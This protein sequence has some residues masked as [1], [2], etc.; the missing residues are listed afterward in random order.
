[1]GKEKI[2]GGEVKSGG[3]AARRSIAVLQGRSAHDCQRVTGIRSAVVQT[4]RNRVGKTG[5]F[6]VHGN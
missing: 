5:L 2:D 6:D 1:M 3:V 4:Q